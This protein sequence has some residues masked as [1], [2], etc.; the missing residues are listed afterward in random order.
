MVTSSTPLGGAPPASSGVAHPAGG[1]SCFGFCAARAFDEGAAEI[2]VGPAEAFAASFA[3]AVAVGAGVARVADGSFAPALFA[4]ADDVLAERDG[5]LPFAGE[6]FAAVFAGEVAALVLAGEDFAAVF[7]GEAA[8]LP[9]ADEV[10]AVLFAEDDEAL[11]FAGEVFAVLFAEDDDALLFAGED[12]AVLFA[13][14]DEALVFADPLAAF[15]FAASFAFAVAVGAGFARVEDGSFAPADD[16]RE[17]AVFAVSR[18]AAATLWAASLVAPLAALP[19]AAL[20][21][22]GLSPRF[23]ERLTGRERGRLERTSRCV[24]SAIGRSLCRT[25]VRDSVHAETFIDFNQH[26]HRLRA[27]F[28]RRPRYAA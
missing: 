24:S 23:R 22:E 1:A 7:A 26:I 13:E 12:F 10:F 2:G 16:R 17:G 27:S 4:F 14:D 11:L 19:S 9:F 3:F 5:A 15:F 28:W 6:D 21:L 8:V 25:L 20:R 18:A